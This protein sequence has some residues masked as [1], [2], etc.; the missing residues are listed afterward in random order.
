MSR[1]APSPVGT[2]LLDDP[3]ADPGEVASSLG[4]IARANRWFGGRAAAVWGVR[5]LLDRW[6]P[7]RPI[8]LLDVGTGTGDLPAAI[9]RSLAERGLTLR[10]VG[11]ERSPVAARLAHAGGLPT[12]LACAGALPVR[13]RSVD[14]VLLSQFVHHL[15]PAA[16]VELLRGVTRLARLGVVVSDLR[17]SRAAVAAFRLGSSALR[18]DTATRADGVTSLRRGYTA[19][20]LAGL[21]ASAGVRATVARRPGFRLV[22]TW[23]SP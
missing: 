12:V 10:A 11:L 17:R 20:E 21:A 4:H 2:E 22:A 18:F 14:I 5:R 16:V 9:R 1:L 19:A 6:P 8:L 13:P 23:R 7:A 3:A 15:A